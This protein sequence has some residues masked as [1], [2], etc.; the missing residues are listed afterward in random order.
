MILK[1]LFHSP[2]LRIGNS[3]EETCHLFS[4]GITNVKKR[5]LPSPLDLFC[6]QT[7]FHLVSVVPTGF[8]SE[9]IASPGFDGEQCSG[10][11][12][13]GQAQL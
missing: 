11:A 2:K 8:I 5:W 9:R 6:D 10:E 3:E 12:H 13:G 1:S 4:L 7:E